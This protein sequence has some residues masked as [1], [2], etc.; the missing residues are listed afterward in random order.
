MY[1]YIFIFF[2]ISYLLLRAYIKIKYKFWSIQPVFHLYNLSYWIF[3]PG[4]LKKNKPEINKYTN[5]KEITFTNFER[6][7]NIDLFVEFIQKYYLNTSQIKFIP[8]KNN[9]IPYFNNTKK[10]FFSI[11]KKNNEIVGVMTSRILNVTLNNV[12][13]PTYYVDYLCVKTENRKSGIAQQI[14]QTHDYNQR[15]FTNV[16]SSLFKRENQLN[17]IIPLV[18]YITFGYNIEK[19]NNTILLHDSLS[20]VTIN[21]N[22]INNFINFIKQNTNKFDIC[23]SPEIKVILQ[24]IESNNVYIYALYQGETMICIYMFRDASTTYNSKQTINLFA[25]INN[26]ISDEFIKGFYLCMNNFKDKYKYIIVENLSQNNIIINNINSK[27]KPF[28]KSPTA[29]YFYNFITRPLL[30][31]KVFIIN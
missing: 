27:Y 28:I 20:L 7:D 5:L 23:I 10:S 30:S 12:K 4:T 13:F 14:I 18:T 31:N 15:T 1:I 17:A 19:W 26:T 3:P 21:K 22:N 29:Y 9:I 6:L 16:S 25:S 24:L 11:Y 2:I 8:T